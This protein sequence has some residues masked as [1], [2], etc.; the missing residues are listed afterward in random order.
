M[1]RQWQWSYD[2]GA[3]GAYIPFDQEVSDRIE[4]EFLLKGDGATFPVTLGRN[5]WL[6]RYDKELKAWVQV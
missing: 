4:W 6:I 1:D 5:E 3:A 2:G